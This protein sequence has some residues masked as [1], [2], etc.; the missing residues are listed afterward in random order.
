MIGKFTDGDF[1]MSQCKGQYSLI[2]AINTVDVIKR[3]TADAGYL[4]F[5]NETT[6]WSLISV[7]Q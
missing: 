1:D 6:G 3:M 7:Q 2:K 4:F 5:V